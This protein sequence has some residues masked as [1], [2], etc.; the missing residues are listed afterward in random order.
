MCGIFGLVL[1]KE[2]HV[3]AGDA[4]NIAESLFCISESR[5]REA[6]G[7]AIYRG[8]EV[9]ALKQPVPASQLIRTDAFDRLWQQGWE[10]GAVRSF[11]GHARL[12][13]NG[14]LED[15]LNNQ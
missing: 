6:S 10:K 13:T 12:V 15:N 14:S 9:F 4:K 11:I 2:S 3:G 5:G 8:E 7:M 1:K